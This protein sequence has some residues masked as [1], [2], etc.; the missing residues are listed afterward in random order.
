MILLNSDAYCDRE[1]GT[2]NITTDF[3]IP[4]TFDDAFSDQRQLEKVALAKSI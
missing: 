4:K 2:P 3:D 1:E